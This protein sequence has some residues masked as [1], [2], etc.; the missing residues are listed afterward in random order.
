MNSYESSVGERTGA[1]KSITVQVVARR[2]AHITF[3][4]RLS[5]PY[6]IAVMDSTHDIVKRIMVL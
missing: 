3:D 1:D 4:A 2:V 5:I 6:L